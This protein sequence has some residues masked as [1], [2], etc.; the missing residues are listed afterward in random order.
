M[1]DQW[2]SEK[3]P[4]GL[5]YAGDARRDRPLLDR[6]GI[7]PWAGHVTVTHVHGVGFEVAASWEGPPLE[8]AGRPDAHHLAVAG[9]ATAAAVATLAND[10]YYVQDE[11]LARAI[12]ETAAEQLRA[13]NRPSLPAIG[14][15]LKRRES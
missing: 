2:R 15:D 14:A 5:G 3:L 13:P 12:A 10:V 7:G 9:D 11:A 6:Q 1:T 8:V 4:G